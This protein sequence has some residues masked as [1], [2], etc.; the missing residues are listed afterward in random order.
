MS[1][2]VPAPMSAPV[3]A[4]APVPMSAP[5]PAPEPVSVCPVNVNETVC[6][7]G[8]GC[9][10]STYMSDLMKQ[11]LN[12]ERVTL[13]TEIAR[14]IEFIRSFQARLDTIEIQEKHYSLV[15]HVALGEIVTVA[16]EEWEN[17]QLC[18][19]RCGVFLCEIE[20]PSASRPSYVTARRHISLPL[21]A[22]PTEP[23]SRRNYNQKTI[24]V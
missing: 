8:C 21:Y 23:P 12:S 5:V 20:G 13:E 22:P 15:N 24:T 11:S 7:P 19:T 10:S 17:F 2:P 14:H 3:S 4:P 18:A 16:A 6:W 1:A 9:S